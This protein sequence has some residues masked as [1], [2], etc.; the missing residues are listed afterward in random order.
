MKL[1]CRAGEGTITAAFDDDRRLT[2]VTIRGN[3]Q[4]MT[5]TPDM[6]EVV[7]SIFDILH[8]NAIGHDGEWRIDV[9]QIGEGPI[10]GKRAWDMLRERK[11]KTT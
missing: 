6:M 11:E 1:K 9:C 8:I 10:G 5:L 3:K 4:V 2:E 7:A